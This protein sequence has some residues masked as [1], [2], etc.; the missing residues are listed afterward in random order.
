MRLPPI[1]KRQVSAVLLAV[2]A[3]MLMDSLYQ[4]AMHIRWWCWIP[5]PSAVA[6][7][8]T[9]PASTEPSSV[10]AASQAGSKPSSTR[11]VASRVAGTQPAGTRPAATQADSS[12]P[13]ASQPAGMPQDVRRPGGPPGSRPTAKPPKPHELAGGIKKRN[14][15]AEPKPTGHG[16]SLTG[17]LDNVAFFR[18]REGRD[19]SIEEGK[20][21]EGGVKVTKID[22]ASVTIEYEGKPET[23]WMFAATGATPPGGRPEP[24]GRAEAGRPGSPGAESVGP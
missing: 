16:L 22:G 24:T 5:T 18:S 17:V 19:V 2:A 12:Q 15:M 8:G 14:V 20:S 3:L 11:A 4:V 23:V 1:N 13:T 21:G 6:A 9:Q 7:P 10:A